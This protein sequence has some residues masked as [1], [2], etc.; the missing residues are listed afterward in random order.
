VIIL[1]YFFEAQVLNIHDLNTNLN[2]LSSNVLLLYCIF[3]RSKF[4]FVLN[5]WTH[6]FVYGL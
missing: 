4:S 1:E 6:N 2:Y 5:S 3:W